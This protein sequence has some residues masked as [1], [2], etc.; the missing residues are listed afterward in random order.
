MADEA[1]RLYTRKDAVPYIH[2]KFGIPISHSRLEK[3][4]MAE[5]GRLPPPTKIFGR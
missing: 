2:E 1:K 5:V 4:A 3:N